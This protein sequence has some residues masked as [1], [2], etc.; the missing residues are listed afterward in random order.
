PGVSI[1]RQQGEGRFVTV[2]GFGPEFNTVLLN[3][4]VLATDND[5]REFSFDVLP[6]ELISG[7]DVFK[8]SQANFQEGGIGSTINIRTARPTDRAGVF[9]AGS[10]AGKYD[11]GSENTTPSASVLFSKSNADRTF[12]VLGSLVYDKR[13]ARVYRFSTDGWLA[14]Q[15]LDF[16]KDGITDLADVAVD[17]G[18]GQSVDT[19]SRE[20]IGGTLAVDWKPSDRLTVKLDALYTQYKVDS[21]V[22]A[23]GYFSDP[24]DIISAT[25][26]ANGTLIHYVRSNTGSLATDNTYNAAPRD[27]KTYQLGANFDYKLSDR[28]TITTDLS[29][30]KAR[31]D[32]RDGVP[33]MVIGSRNTGLNPTWDLRP[34]LPTPVVSNVYPATDTDRARGHFSIRTGSDITDEV[35]QLRVDGSHKF[36]GALN[37]LRFGLLASDR[38]KTTMAYQTPGAIL[39]AYCGYYATLPAGLAQVFDSGQSVFLGN[40]ELTTKWLTFDPDAL[41]AY[42]ASDAAISQMPVANQAAFRAAFAANGNSYRGVLSPLGSGSV[43]EKSY[44]LYLQ[45]EFAGEISGMPWDADAGLRWVSTELVAEGSS[46][47]LVSITTQAGDNTQLNYTLSDPVPVRVKN[48]YNYVLPSATFRLNFTDKLVGRAAISRTLTRPTLTNLGVSQSYT[49]RPPQS[50]YSSG[51]NPDLKPYLAWNA[52]LAIDYY[53][54]R[55][56]YVSLAAFHK[57]VTNFVS[58]V[59]QPREILG[60]TFQDTRPTNAQEAEIDGLEAAFQ[61]TFDFLPSP[62]D[63]L[64]LSA[65]YTKVDSS[66]AFDPSLSTQVFNVEGLSDSANLVVFYEKG[67]IQLRAAYNWRAKF[68]NRT[69]GSEGQPENY[70]A[71]G[72][73]DM[74]ASY[75]V[76]PHL[77]AFIEGLNLTDEKTRSYA[78]YEERLLTLE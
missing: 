12:G 56:A 75:K 53:F 65:N 72:Q 29:Y 36:D 3:G 35:T 50:F 33:V 23:M 16:N 67:P 15:D 54:N 47:Q 41:A 26:N 59:T 43:A 17:R 5:G 42:Y 62:F 60:Y 63:G 13:D 6:S 37:T 68:L 52:D 27:A 1:N 44:A 31:N 39:C 4:R 9:M 21:R 20:R 30:S 74:Q 64:G 11:S 45:G 18:A 40:P 55:S 38:T 70:D 69:F 14:H 8:S 19:S 71:Y 66:V 77:T 46:Q 73:L 57:K 48:T 28:T 25:A 34:D 22:Y 10:L 2:R 78:A 76:T 61:Y 32:G 49:L 51:G 7:A 24:A 58:L